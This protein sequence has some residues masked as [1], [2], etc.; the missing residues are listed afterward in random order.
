MEVMYDGVV[1]F[2]A[3][4]ETPECGR[5]DNV[6]GSDTFC[7]ERCGAEHA[8][9]GYLRTERIGENDDDS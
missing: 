9:G 6:C 7:S 1:A 4:D 3:D 2:T 5:C 8:W